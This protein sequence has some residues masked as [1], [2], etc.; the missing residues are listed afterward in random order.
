M[1]VYLLMENDLNTELV[2]AIRHDLHK[3]C[4]K[5]HTGKHN[6]KAGKPDGDAA[7]MSR[8]RINSP[9]WDNDDR[10]YRRSLITG[11]FLMPEYQ[12]SRIHLQDNLMKKYDK[13]HANAE[14]MFMTLLNCT[15][16]SLFNESPDLAFTSLKY[17]SILTTVLYYNYLRNYKFKDLCFAIIDIDDEHN[18]FESI[19]LDNINNKCIVLKP[20]DDKLK[21]FTKLKSPIENFDYA[22]SRCGNTE[23]IDPYV[24]SNL[25][26]ISSWSTGL[27]FYED[28]LSGMYIKEQQN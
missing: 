5:P 12:E 3:I 16:L 27:Q 25:R 8:N 26:R 14:T 10:D 23:H 18:L 1:G 17:H 13:N 15:E 28:I 6:F 22:I 2:M 19:F 9:E 11:Q 7:R 4:G 24:Y 20:F 21:L